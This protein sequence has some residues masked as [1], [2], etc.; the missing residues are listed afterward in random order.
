MCVY[1]LHE[2][3]NEETLQILTSIQTKL[4]KIV[5]LDGK[6]VFRTLFQAFPVELDKVYFETDEEHIFE[7]IFGYKKSFHAYL[8][9]GEFYFKRFGSIEP[10]EYD[11]IYVP[12]IIQDIVVY[13]LNEVAGKVMYLFSEKTWK[14]Y[15]TRRKPIYVEDDKLVVESSEV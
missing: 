7:R 8:K 15:N 5:E 14:E 13:D 11:A 2:I 1:T 10:E 12:C 4:L 6:E 9:S 3:N